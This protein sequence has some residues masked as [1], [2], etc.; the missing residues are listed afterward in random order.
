MR[1]SYIKVAKKLTYTFWS[2]WFL[3][4]AGSISA[5]KSDISILIIILVLFHH[6]VMPVL[7][8]SI[9]N[10]LSS[11]G[12]S[13][14]HWR[15]FCPPGVTLVLNTCILNIILIDQI[16]IRYWIVGC[17]TEVH[18]AVGI[19]L[20]RGKTYFAG[21]KWSNHLAVCACHDRPWLVSSLFGILIAVYKLKNINGYLDMWVCILLNAGSKLENQLWNTITQWP[22]W[23]NL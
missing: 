17:S 6:C 2:Y 1:W 5:I 19:F 23:S 11:P 8:S 21:N 20:Q 9:L 22:F 14:L 13:S 10:L 3:W 12:A 16:W 18:T 7:D 15:T 4:S